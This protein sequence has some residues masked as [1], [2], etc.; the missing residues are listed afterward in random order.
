MNE[1]DVNE[2]RSETSGSRDEQFVMTN[3][4]KRT[5]VGGGQEEKHRGCN[6]CDIYR[7]QRSEGLESSN[8]KKNQPYL[9]FQWCLIIYSLFD[10]SISGGL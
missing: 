2:R 9:S 4:I 8:K 6:F 10:R 3:A 1:H 5:I 7:G